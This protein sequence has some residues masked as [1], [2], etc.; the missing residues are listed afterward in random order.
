LS[1]GG[2]QIYYAALA[3]AQ[4]QVLRAVAMERVRA[5]SRRVRQEVGIPRASQITCSAGNRRRRSVAVPDR[6]PSAG[7]HIVGAASHDR[8]LAIAAS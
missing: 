6:E 8:L 2:W 5:L 4:P 1:A 7:D 3:E